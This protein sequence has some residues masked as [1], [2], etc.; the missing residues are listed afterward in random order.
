MHPL[1]AAWG[2]DS[3]TLSR[4]LAQ[5]AYLHSQA[6]RYAPSALHVQGDNW[7]GRIVASMPELCFI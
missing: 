2:V 1:C 7:T 4:V 6:S 5:L 3:I